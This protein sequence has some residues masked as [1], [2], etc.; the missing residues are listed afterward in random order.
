MCVPVSAAAF[1]LG[2]WAGH[3]LLRPHTGIAVGG[4]VMGCGIAVCL[5]TIWPFKTIAAWIDPK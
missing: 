3:E 4:F 1:F 2:L 5:I